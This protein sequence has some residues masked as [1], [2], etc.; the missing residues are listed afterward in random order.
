MTATVEFPQVDEGLYDVWTTWKS[1]S[2]LG[3]GTYELFVQDD[4]TR[5][6]TP[7][8]GFG[9]GMLRDESTRIFRRTT[10][11]SDHTYVPVDFKSAPRDTHDDGVQGLRWFSVGTVQVDSQSKLSLRLQKDAGQVAIDGFRLT[12]HV[13]REVIEYDQANRPTHS[14]LY[15]ERASTAR[16]E[17]YY[18]YDVTGKM[19]AV[20]NL[21]LVMDSKSTL[22]FAYQGNQQLLSFSLDTYSGG[23]NEYGKIKSFNLLGT[24]GEVLGIDS[25]RFGQ[26]AA[27]ASQQQTVWQINNLDGTRFTDTNGWFA[28]NYAFAGQKLASTNTDY[29][30][31][32]RDAHRNTWSDSTPSAWG[33]FNSELWQTGSFKVASDAWNSLSPETT[34]RIG[35]GLQLG[36]GLAQAGA[37]IAAGIASCPVTLGV[38]CAA[39]IAGAFIGVDNAIAGF[40]TL[41]TGKTAET[42]LNMEVAATA[43]QFMSEQNA[44]RLATGV[45]LVA[46]LGAGVG[47]DLVRATSKFA[48][49][50][51][52]VLDDAAKAQ[53][54]VVGSFKID[55]TNPPPQGWRYWTTPYSPKFANPRIVDPATGLKVPTSAL[56]SKT[57]LHELQHF[58]DA[59]QHPQLYYFARASNAPGA[60]LAHFVFETRGYLQSHG[61]QALFNPS[62]AM[63]SVR[64]AGRAHL[65]YRDLAGLAGLGGLGGFAYWFTSNESGQE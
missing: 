22:G 46:G 13:R 48:K 1:S 16:T 21:D 33:T 41:R 32:S 44:Q 24:Q 53:G 2:S 59:T 51:V 3:S 42:L 11:S 14:L 52:N 56:G 34:A 50:P 64:H 58:L 63:A 18:A 25:S 43:R 36:Y 57:G 65:V 8:G 10:N 29:L 7:P 62:L 28:T 61:L 35:G 5:A 17:T 60:G 26:L 4:F 39:G 20:R 9:W 55:L 15:S 30:T 19:V 54:K 27:I 31:Q 40:E 6:N 45:E 37:S 23:V 49:A 38:G 47:D 12:P